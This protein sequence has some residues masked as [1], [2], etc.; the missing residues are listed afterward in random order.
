MF[1]HK[2]PGYFH[3]HMRRNMEDFVT[4]TD[5]S[6]IRKHVLEYNEEVSIIPVLVVGLLSTPWYSTV[7]II[8][9]LWGVARE[10][11][12]VIFCEE[13][14]SEALLFQRELLQ[15]IHSYG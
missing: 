13:S 7:C 9:V 8:A 4:W 3:L 6:K 15:T 12:F 11:A 5:T 10:E 2:Q 1:A 14:L